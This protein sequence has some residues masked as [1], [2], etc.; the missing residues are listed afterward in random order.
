M[1]NFACY[2]LFGTINTTNDAVMKSDLS[3]KPD[4]GVYV[5]NANIPKGLSKIIT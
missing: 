2:T 1:Y 3:E 5:K 4:T